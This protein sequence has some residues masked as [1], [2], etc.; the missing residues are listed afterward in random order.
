MLDYDALAVEVLR[1]MYQLI[2]NGYCY[3]E[4]AMNEDDQPCTVSDKRAVKFDLYGSLYKMVRGMNQ[5]DVNQKTKLENWVSAALKQA[6]PLPDGADLH[7]Y[8]VVEFC[9]L[10]P[11][12]DDVLHVIN[13]AMLEIDPSQKPMTPRRKQMIGRK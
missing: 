6:I 12:R 1:G 2:S 10:H 5:L 8:A 3:H 11:Q 9:K 4:S 13:L 7:R